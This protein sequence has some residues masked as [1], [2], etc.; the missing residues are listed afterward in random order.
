[1]K[2][3]FL[4]GTPL[5]KVWADKVNLEWYLK[6]GFDLEFWNLDRIYYSLYQIQN[7]FSDNKF[8]SYEPP[9]QKIFYNKTDVKKELYKTDKNTIFCFLDFANHDDFWLRRLLRIIDAN[10]YVGPRVVGFH[11][12]KYLIDSNLKYVTYLMKRFFDSFSDENF[13]KRYNVISRLKNFLYRYTNYYQ[14]PIFV[15]SSGVAGRQMWMKKTLA[16]DFLSIPS[17][18]IDWTEKERIIKY[19]YGLFVDDTIFSSPDYRMNH[20]DKNFRSHDIQKYIFNL[21]S[22]FDLIEKKMNLKIIIAASGKYI[23][24]NNPYNRE[25]IYQRTAELIQHANVI[26]GH[27][28][29]ALNQAIVNKKP[30]LM[31][32]DSTIKKEKRMKIQYVSN[33]LNINPLNIEHFSENELDTNLNNIYNTNSVI[34]KFFFENINNDQVV[35]S[36]EIIA[37][38]INSIEL[39]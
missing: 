34:K 20:G 6:N 8:L 17:V 7:Y 18:E 26:I 35:P 16:S 3:I 38:K 15:A 24:D 33:Y 39:S 13:F 10:Y 4:N 5:A 14:K 9:N 19:E 1:M 12:E 23:Y 11:G 32:F 21:Q 27:N 22:F 2:I 28:S 30:T 37:K 36:Y 25:I 29:S 31:I